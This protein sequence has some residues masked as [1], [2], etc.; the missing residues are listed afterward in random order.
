MITCAECKKEFA[1][2]GI[3]HRHVRSHGLLK[4]SYYHKHFPR[5]D[6]FTK[7]LL[8]FKNK[9]YYFGSIFANRSNCIGYIK[10]LPD[11]Q[12][13]EFIRELFSKRKEAKGIL[14]QPCQVELRST[15]LPSVLFLNKI[16]F[17]YNK[18]AEDLG[19]IQKYNYNVKTY[20][21]QFHQEPLEIIQDT[22]EQK[23]LQF[24]KSKII[25]S[26]LNVGDYCCKSHFNNVF[27]ERKSPQDFIGTFGGQIERFEREIARATMINA[28]IFV[29]VEMSLDDML[30]FR[31]F[32]FLARR[33][34]YTPEYIFHN[35]RE[36]I[37]KHPNIQFG[38]CDGRVQMVSIIER[39]CSLKSN[40]IKYD[41]QH[42]IDL[43][44]L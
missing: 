15:I 13:S 18:M 37:Q 11:K 41:V 2:D 28:T 43:G 16:G 22:R 27:I 1:D 36:L 14:Y 23:P 42:L 17:D 35:V 3:L 25:K 10:Q 33:T 31:E 12:K 32:P 20:D 30:V 7:K 8:E 21:F 6:I 34:P 38:F 9:E 4:E 29:L 19:L 26:G 40:I 44:V 24:P 5:Y 39:I